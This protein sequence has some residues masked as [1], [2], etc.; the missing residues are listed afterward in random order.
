MC[1]CVAERKPLHNNNNRTWQLELEKH[2]EQSVADD[3]DSHESTTTTRRMKKPTKKCQ[4]TRR[5]KFSRCDFGRV[6]IAALRF[7]SNCAKILYFYIL[8][9]VAKIIISFRR[10]AAHTYYSS[11]EKPPQHAQYSHLTKSNYF[12]FAL[13]AACVCSLFFHFFLFFIIHSFVFLAVFGVSVCLAVVV[14]WDYLLAPTLACTTLNGKREW[15]RQT[16]TKEI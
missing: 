10:N 14:V 5:K 7:L 13:M 4:F 6:M 9:F 3:Y 15:K 1:G 12:W 2:G 11:S 8:F 16:K